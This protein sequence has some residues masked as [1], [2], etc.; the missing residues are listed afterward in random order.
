MTP[1]KLVSQRRDQGRKVKMIYQSMVLFM[2]SYQLTKTV[3][4][5]R[6]KSSPIV[7]GR[8]GNPIFITNNLEFLIVRFSGI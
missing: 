6:L 3:T 8:V 7:S 1:S 4:I 2:F 5:T